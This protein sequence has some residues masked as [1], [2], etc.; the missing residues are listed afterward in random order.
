MNIK[1]ILL[2]LYIAIIPMSALN[3]SRSIH[4]LFFAGLNCSY[5]TIESFYYLSGKTY[6]LPDNSHLFSP[7]IV[8]GKR[9]SFNRFLFLSASA[10]CSY[11]LNKYDLTYPLV[12]NNQ[13]SDCHFYKTYLQIGTTSLIHL[14]LPGDSKTFF[15]SVAVGGGIHYSFYKEIEREKNGEKKF[16]IDDYLVKHSKPAGSLDLGIYMDI[17]RSA[18]KCWCLNYNVRVWQTVNYQVSKD[19]FPVEPVKYQ[20]FFITH[21]LGIT[22]LFR[23][24]L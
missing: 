15:F 13:L 23:P 14:Q 11:G 3:S 2:I 21:R 4:S 12:I 18:G 5:S 22:Y 6:H 8:I 9:F 10:H 19:L 17:P 16:V 7:E 24:F 1:L 20:E